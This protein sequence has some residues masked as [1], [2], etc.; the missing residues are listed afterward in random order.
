MPTGTQLPHTLHIVHA[1]DHAKFADA[2]AVI[3]RVQRNGH[4]VDSIQVRSAGTAAELAHKITEPAGAILFTGHGA[5]SGI[6]TERNWLL[7]FSQIKAL[8]GR[9]ISTNGLIV[10][11]CDGWNAHQAISRQASRKF[12]YLAADGQ[13][14]Y[15]HALLITN[16]ILCLVAPRQPLLG[17][18]EDVRMAI[19]RAFAAT[20]QGW[21]HGRHSLWRQS[22]MTPPHLAR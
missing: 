1:G 20:E 6:G 21:P 13:P 12:A 3:A 16:V 2:L 18:A 5:A 10:D 8:A 7:D 19:N 15:T 17:S 4:Q 22:I 14:P 9:P 11:A